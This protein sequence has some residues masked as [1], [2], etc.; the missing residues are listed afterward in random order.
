MFYKQ[1]PDCSQFPKTAYLAYDFITGAFKDM[2]P[3][4]R[5]LSCHMVIDVA[6]GNDHHWLQKHAA[7]IPGFHHGQD[8]FAVGAASMVPMK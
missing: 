4:I 6:A 3:G 7:V 8:V 2:L 5:A 1:I